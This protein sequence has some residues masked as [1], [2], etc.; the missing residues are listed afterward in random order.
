VNAAILPR[1]RGSPGSR[2]AVATLVALACATWGLGSEGSL[3]SVSTDL[4][5][6]ASFDSN[7]FLQDNEPAPSVANAARPSQ[8]SFVSSIAPRITWGF[9]PNAGFT[10]SASYSP[11]IVTYHQERREDHVAH[12]GSVHFGGVVGIVT[13]Q[14]QNSLTWIDGCK[15]GLTF[16][17]PGGA[18]AI[19][20]IAIRDRREAIIYRNS[21]GA[22]HKHGSWFFRPA[23]SSYIHDFRTT[24][25]DP[26]QFPYYQNYVDRNDFN[27]GLDAGFKA[28]KDGYIFVAYRIGWQHEPSLPKVGFDYSNDYRRLLLGFEGRVTERL[29]LNL[30]V[31]PDWR[32]FNHRPPAGFDATPL[33]LF[34]DGSAV[35]A[36]SAADSLTLTVKRY[37][38]PAFGAPSAYEDITYE[39]QWRRKLDERFALAAGFKAY[40]GKWLPPVMREDWIYTPSASLTFKHS[41]R[42]TLDF[43]WSWDRARS[44][45]PDKHGR[46]FTRHLV[47]LGFRIAL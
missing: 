19:G 45:I 7:V 38:Q 3:W 24:E 43:A 13:W 25:R 16:G 27:L 1:R 41:E 17:G 44:S 12:R 14:L 42:L 9:K 39:L 46:D 21:F 10:V 26:A 29:K 23:V 4:A 6:K 35:F 36:V 8:E 31:G 32:K 5:L 15:E 22:F 37:A 33:K 20:G 30:F 40:G 11:E 47:S 18:P 34:I 28:L 2:F